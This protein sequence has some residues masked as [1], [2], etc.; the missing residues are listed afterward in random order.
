M[1]PS[2]E[3]TRRQDYEA[4]LETEAEGNILLDLDPS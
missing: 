4:T 3:F 2:S 1:E